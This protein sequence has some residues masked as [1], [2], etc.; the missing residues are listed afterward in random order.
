M[1]D[2]SVMRTDYTTPVT[3]AVKPEAEPYPAKY[4][5]ILEAALELFA[6]YTYDGTAMPLVAERA[7]VGAGTIYRYFKSKEALVNAV[8]RRCMGEQRRLLLDGMPK[9]ATPREQFRHWWR[10]MCSFAN[11]HPEAFV[12]LETHHHASY[13]DAES[14]RLL[15]DV[16]TGA[17]AL[18][19]HAQASGKVRQTPPEML[20][21][22]IFGAFNGLAK[23]TRSEGRTLTEE[24]IAQGEECV[25]QML[26]P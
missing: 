4:E 23:S 8:Y 19:E 13:V 16:R 26:K 5:A 1:N 18:I 11:E 15:D 12:F 3:S 25:W 24:A 2:H 20:M 7:G 21:S 9:A 22:L 6:E 17:R 14:E 10:G